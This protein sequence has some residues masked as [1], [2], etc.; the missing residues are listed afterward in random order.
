MIDYFFF[1]PV[2]CFLPFSFKYRSKNRNEEIKTEG[3]FLAR[4]KRS[5]FELVKCPFCGVD[6]L[7]PLAKYCS[8]CGK[9]LEIN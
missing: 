6:I 3:N 4:G 7:D 1:I 2:I 8:Q 9:K 5:E